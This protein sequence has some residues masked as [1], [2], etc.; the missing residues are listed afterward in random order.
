MSGVKYPFYM[1]KA[2][3]PVC[4]N[5]TEHFVFKSKIVIP[6]KTDADNYVLLYQWI[7]KSYKKCCPSFYALWTCITC[8]YTDFPEFFEKH[9]ETPSYE[10]KQLKDIILRETADNEGV[11]YKLLSP[12][13]LNVP[14]L[15]FETVMNM[16]QLA[17]YCHNYLFKENK[18]YEQLGRLYLRT[19]WLFREFESLKIKNREYAGYPSYWEFLESLK[20]QWP[21][22]PTTEK[23]CYAKAAYYFSEIIHQ[24]FTYDEAVKNIKIILLAAELYSRSKDYREAYSILHNVISLGMNLRNEIRRMIREKKQTGE[25]KPSETSFL[26]SRIDKISDQLSGVRD[27]YL[28]VQEEWSKL[29]TDRVDS[30]IKDNPGLEKEEILKKLS[31][32]KIPHEMVQFLRGHDLRFHSSG[33]NKKKWYFWKKK[34]I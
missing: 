31:E 6:R 4:R 25:L 17:I 34:S 8:G 28:D 14:E 3:C 33:S 5:F 32:Q 11:L 10:F 22:I 1:K 15:E 2:E 26:F 27:K 12:V 23:F 30:V 21:T 13:D 19:A 16:H 18:D 29:Y 9:L 7:D 20:S 24:D